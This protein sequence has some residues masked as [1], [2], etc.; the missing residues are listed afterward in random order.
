MKKCVFW[1]FIIIAIILFVWMRQKP[2]T[3]RPVSPRYSAQLMTP[4]HNTSN[5]PNNRLNQQKHRLSLN[6]TTEFFIEK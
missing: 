3:A 2:M 1:I 5:L 6:S 4:V